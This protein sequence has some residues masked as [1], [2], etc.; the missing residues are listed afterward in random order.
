MKELIDAGLETLV[1]NDG[2]LLVNDVHERSITHRLG[3]YYQA[4]FPH[5][6][7][8]CEYNKNLGNPKRISIDPRLFLSR[9]AQII[10]SSGVFENSNFFA[11]EIRNE[12]IAIDDLINLRHQLED[13]NRLIYNKEFDV[14]YFVLT[15]RDGGKL[16][17][18]I[19]PDIIV[20]KRGKKDNH[21]VIEAKNSSNTDPISRAYDIIKLATLVTD[22]EFG[23]KRGYFI[24][25]PTG[26]DYTN[27]TKFIYSRDFF[28]KN[29]YKVTSK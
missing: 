24:D 10:E 22:K 20:H 4:L 29:V 25:I 15:L 12:H 23:Y 21:I 5:W 8:D 11:S 3:M 9:M 13:P 1:I 16:T 2:Y 6:D 26:I 17:K 7:V 14:L 27:H 28:S 19:Y 18:Q